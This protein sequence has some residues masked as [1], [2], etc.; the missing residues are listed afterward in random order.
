MKHLKVFITILL[1]FLLTSCT[2]SETP[3][4]KDSFVPSTEL[5]VHFLDVGQGD[6]I[7]IELPNGETMLIDAGEKRYADVVSD[8]LT[9]LAITKIDYVVGTH[10]HTDH[11]GG[12]ADIIASFKTGDIYLPK[13]GSN[14]KT[15]ENLLTTIKE[16]NQVIH[17][18]EKGKK[19]LDE[20]GLQVYFLGPDQKYKNLNNNSAIVKIVYGDTS[21]LFMGDAE[22]MVEAKLEDV[23]ADVIKV[24]HHGSDSSSSDDFVT[25]VK[26][27][28]AVISVGANNQYNHPSS[29]TIKK[30]E[31]IGATVYR[32]DQNGNIIISS[33]GKNLEVT[34]AKEANDAS[35]S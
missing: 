28:Y 10:P 30:Y 15:Y 1:V 20:K 11:I 21:F 31:D 24:G 13:V 25:Q 29:E 4:V 5:K 12:L 3:I 22:T 7:F 18:A 26:P 17:V 23:K 19:I 33:D 34:L 27:Q 14:T 9:E 16:Q 35:N 6:S 2:F 8:Y 32:T